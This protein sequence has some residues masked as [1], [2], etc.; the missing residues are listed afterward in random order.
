MKPSSHLAAALAFGLSVATLPAAPRAAEKTPTSD[1]A[2]IWTLTSTIVEGSVSAT[3]ELER[4]GERYAGRSGPLDPL[5]A[6]PLSYTGGSAGGEL[7]LS[8]SCRNQPVGV[9]VLKMKRSG[10]IGDGRIFGTPV[11]LSAI[12]PAAGPS[13]AARTHTYDPV[14]YHPITSSAPEPVLRVAPGDTIRTRTIDPYGIDNHDASASMPGNPGTGP[15]YVEGALPGDTVTVRIKSLKT[16]RTTARMN[17]ALD[18]AVLA[19]GYA[20]QPGAVSD[21]F[22]L[23]DPAEGT[24]RLRSP[25]DKLKDFRAPLRPML[26]V[27]TVALAGGRAVPNREIG[28][29]GGNL[30]YPEIREGVTLYL[31]VFQ[32]G[33]LI[34]LGDGHARQSDGE[35]TGQGLET[36]LDVEFE[37]GVIKGQAFPQPWAEN[38]DYVMVSGIWGSADGALRRATTGMAMWLKQTYQLDDS[39][40]AAVMGVSLQYDVAAVIGA[41]THVVAKIRKDVL[42]Q[43][44]RS[45]P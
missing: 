28:E 26:G 7:R 19:P 45:K 29:W 41:Q 42:A 30:D 31:P 38:P 32:P 34:F 13:G 11:R 40:V 24:A 27:V 10:L 14:A 4:D 20:P 36:S 35:V 6:C 33:A 21:V 18:P 37:V 8:V 12:R 3:M 25:S 44:P 43:L 1:L 5:Q 15:F 2:G 16:N 39:E 9:I 23:L 17:V 22:W